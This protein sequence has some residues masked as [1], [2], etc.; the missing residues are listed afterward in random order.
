[1]IRKALF[2]LAAFSAPL[3]YSA[4]AQFSVYGDV[5]LEH[6]TGI[7]SS[8][9][10]QTLSPPPCS[11]TTSSTTLCTAYNDSVNPIGFTGG[12]SYDFKTIGSV[13][14]AADARGIVESDHRGAGTN[15]EGPGTRIY[16]GLGGVKASFHTRLD[17]LI[18][19]VQGSA[20]YARSNYGVLT[21]AT[22]VSNSAN[23]VYPG[24]ST[25]NNLEYHVFA[26]LDLR[27][28]AWADWRVVELG[29]GG[30]QAFGTYSHSY[31]IYSVSTGV[32]FHIPPRQ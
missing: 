27:A 21:N 24:I 22:V 10:L 17:Y 7:Q 1:M 26:G 29:Y 25:K 28:L 20:G 4:Q 2:L 13:T 11:G 15:F 31:P 5:T 12:A 9:V 8:P 30:L 32:V 14:L 3:S 19:Y 23:P 18:P 6:M 16:S